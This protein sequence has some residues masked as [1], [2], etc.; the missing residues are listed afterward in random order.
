MSRFQAQPRPLFALAAAMWNHFPRMGERIREVNR[1]R[2][3]LTGAE[4]HDL[5][6]FLYSR[7]PTRTTDA[8]L[9][10]H[11]GAPDRGQQLVADKG[12]LACHSISA[13]QGKRASRFADLKGWDSPWSIVAQMW[14]HAFLMQLDAQEQGIAWAPLSDVEMAD[15]V[16]YLQQLMRAR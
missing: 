4:M 8:R 1:D 2:P 9:L 16:A 12:C 3:Y 11:A 6:A 15:L 7:D 13:P 14:N 10:G 5:V